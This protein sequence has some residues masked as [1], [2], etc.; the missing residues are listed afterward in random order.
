M[1][2]PYV[3]LSL[4]AS[5]VVHADPS[6]PSSFGGKCTL[7]GSWTQ[8]AFFQ[9]NQILSVIKD[10]KENE[11]C[12]GFNSIF[13]SIQKNVERMKPTSAETHGESGAPDD[14]AGG[15]ANIRKTPE[16]LKA[17]FTA[18]KG[19]TDKRFSGLL[20]D[21]VL[22]FVRSI[23]M[24]NTDENFTL[25]EKKPKQ[26]SMTTPE[27]LDSLLRN[28]GDYAEAGLD[29][30]SSMLSNLDEKNN[31][32][33]GRPNELFSLMNSAVF[34]TGAYQTGGEGSQLKL[35]STINTL[36]E[37]VRKNSFFT[38]ERLIH[39][40]ELTTSLSCLME[41]T[42]LNYCAVDDANKIMKMR[43]RLDDEFDSKKTKVQYD[44]NPIAGYYLLT[45][46]LPVLS[47]W[48][49]KVMFGFDPKL[50]TDAIMKNDTISTV[51]DVVYWNNT[52]KSYYSEAL[53]TLDTLETTMAK[54]NH[55]FLLVGKIT[56]E[57]TA[58]RSKENFFLKAVTAQRLPFYLIGYDA[59]NGIPP[60]V[61][62]QEAGKFATTWD[63]WMQGDG[64]FQ[65]M[66]DN[67]EE[68]AIVIRQRLE[69]LGDKALGFASAYFQDRVIVDKSNL[70]VE[71][72]TG[73][74]NVKTSLENIQDYLIAFKA[75]LSTKVG[76]MQSR[77]V[78]ASPAYVIPQIDTTLKQIENVMSA[79][80]RVALLVSD[81]GQSIGTDKEIN[82][83]YRGVI[84]AIF[85]SFNMILQ[86]DTFLMNRMKTFIYYDLVDRIQNQSQLQTNEQEILSIVGE[87]MVNYMAKVNGFNPAA[88]VLD[89]ASAQTVNIQNLEAVEVVFKDYLKSVIA[90]YEMRKNN[91][92]PTAYD[93][94]VDSMFRLQYKDRK[95]WEVVLN[96]VVP[97]TK[98]FMD[99]AEYFQHTDAYPLLI[100]FFTNGQWQARED[101]EN[102][103][104]EKV[105]SYLC[106][107][108]HAFEDV[109]YY[110]GVCKGAKLSNDYASDAPDL[111]LSVSFDE[112][113]EARTKTTQSE[114]D[115][116]YSSRW[117]SPRTEQ[118]CGVRDYLRRNHIYWL[119]KQFLKNQSQ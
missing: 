3:L 15:E 44:S 33:V 75:R 104:F 116:T 103:D 8:Q 51:Q 76:K 6:N 86:R 99:F 84:S 88:E 119:N 4:L 34:L 87:N 2:T 59:G 19:F 109:E 81:T 17:I 14:D 36:L 32:F 60:E 42:T 92:K 113:Y 65:P 12:K 79:F 111:K 50:E 28:K 39:N 93:I 9:A 5:V 73:I 83:A 97:V 91:E 23:G 57:V 70:V 98:P 102:R 56:T 89:Q 1:K 11:G 94:N 100:P 58:L 68:L 90:L 112:L 67:P 40:A 16:E 74:V 13:E 25:G 53:R 55:L 24:L 85:N 107:Q 20:V 35:H 61:A 52:L 117:T 38:A 95:W 101:N 77:F 110:K 69:E 29:I 10:L 45:R 30:V 105:W 31:C 7:N 27:R 48:L 114:G 21:R 106:I 46:E 43:K 47:K 37:V 108:S 18:S 80:N 49:Q 63:V 72:V 115:G 26:N 71:A 22:N 62:L 64:S 78:G 118:V 82:E 41:M 54:K 96:L 66:F